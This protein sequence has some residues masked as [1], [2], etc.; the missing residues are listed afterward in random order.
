MTDIVWVEGEIAPAGGFVNGETG[1]ISPAM[2]CSLVK[3]GSFLMQ[4]EVFKWV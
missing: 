4:L 1:V 2:L 3:H